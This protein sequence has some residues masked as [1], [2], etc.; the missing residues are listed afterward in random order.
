MP[1]SLVIQTSFLGDVVLTTPLVAQLTVHGPVDVVTSPAAA[2]LLA[3]NPDIRRV[4][5]YD[6][7]GRD[8]GLLGL[9]KLAREVRAPDADAV[10]YM[11]QGSVRSAALAL[12]AG[13]RQRVGF[14]TSAGRWLYTQQVP[15]GRAQ[16][17]VERL[18]RLGAGG[19]AVRHPERRLLHFQGQ[20]PER[21]GIVRGHAT[22]G[23]GGRDTQRGS[24]APTPP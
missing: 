15:S 18:W 10:A 20:E 23:D 24:G 19:G 16:H 14:A 8:S 3:N 7:R 13:Y 4:V 12:F 17:H 6:K 11:A 2:G 22:G 5:T 9:R 1:T 21:A